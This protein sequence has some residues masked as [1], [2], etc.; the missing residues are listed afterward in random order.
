MTLFKT[1]DGGVNWTQITPTGTPFYG[2]ISYADSGLL[3]SAGSTTDNF[4]SSYSLNNGSTWT[5]IDGLSHTCLEFL[6][7]TVGYS[8][9][10]A[11]SATVGGIYKFSNALGVKDFNNTSEFS[12]YPNPTSGLMKLS[13]S[14]NTVS[15]V[16]VYDLL[17]KVVLTN[18]YSNLN[19]VSVD[20]SSLKTGV[21]FMKAT[22][23]N[24]GVQT[25]KVVKN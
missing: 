20:L 21:Y 15:N 1:I 22:S 7:S 25:I 6:S 18:N 2:D 11:T 9:G 14:I 17:G 5:A 19:E 23:D 24:G 13:S 8:G 3:V 12:V 4:G 16:A 10:F